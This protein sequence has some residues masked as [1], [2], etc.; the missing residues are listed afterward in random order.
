MS[1]RIAALGAA[2]LILTGLIPAVAAA[3]HSFAMFDPSKPMTL[4]GKV[5][6]LRWTNPHVILLADVSGGPGQP[7]QTWSAEL[8]SPGNLT[9]QGWTKRSLVPGQ[10][11]I[12]VV[13]PLRSGAR[14]GSFSK[15][16]V[17]ETGKVLTYS[18]LASN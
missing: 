4:R 9:R 12:L 13:N 8:T 5:K 10:E 3:H 6:E 2:A 7:V 14:G 18:L 17:V 16:T 15:A 11:I 1:R